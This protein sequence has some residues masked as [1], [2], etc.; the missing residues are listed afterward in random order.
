MSPICVK[1]SGKKRKICIGDFDKRI[2]IFSRQIKIQSDIDVDFNEEFIEQYEVWAMIHT[3]RG[4]ELFDGVSLTNP[5]THKIYIRFKNGI[6][7]EHWIEFN[8]DKYDII[9]VEDLEERHEILLLKSKI[10]GNKDIP[11]NFA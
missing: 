3:S 6:T 9:D 5:F 1:I 11:A 7:Q 4:A 8:N 2:K 10:K